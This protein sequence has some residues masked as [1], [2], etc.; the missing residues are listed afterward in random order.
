MLEFL[1]I[2]TSAGMLLGFA[3]HAVAQSDWDYTPNAQ[4]ALGQNLSQPVPPPVLVQPFGNGYS[5]GAPGQ[6][7]AIIQQTTPG[8]WLVTP[9]LTPP[10][11]PSPYVL[12]PLPTF[13]PL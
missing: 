2:A 8:T 12:Q 3:T 7:P 6:M 4:A 1:R 10:A 9:P 13:P 11:Y 5:V